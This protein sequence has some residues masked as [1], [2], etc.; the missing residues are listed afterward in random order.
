MVANHEKQD[1]FNNY[2]DKVALAGTVISIVLTYYYL[3]DAEIHAFVRLTQHH[4]IQ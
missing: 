2:F 4:R 3:M 1:V